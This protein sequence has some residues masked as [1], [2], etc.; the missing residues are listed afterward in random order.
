MDVTA[1]VRAIAS[2]ILRRKLFDPRMHDEYVQLLPQVALSMATRP[3]LAERLLALERVF[4][5]AK[6]L[7]DFLRH[8]DVL[9]DPPPQGV[10]KAWVVAALAVGL[11]AGLILDRWLS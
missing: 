11:A 3:R 6:N 9:R 7:G 5:D 8:Q 4:V 1:E 2:D 10:A